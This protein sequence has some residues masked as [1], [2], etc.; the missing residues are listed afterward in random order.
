MALGNSSDGTPGETGTT[1]AQAHMMAGWKISESDKPT[2]PERRET[3][4]K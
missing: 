2:K 4:D 3:E 1:S